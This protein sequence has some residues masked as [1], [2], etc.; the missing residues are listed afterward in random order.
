MR[1]SLLILAPLVL[2]ACGETAKLP[3]TAGQG[4]N[5]TLGEPVKTLL[6]TIKIAKPIGWAADATPVAAPGLAVA[7]FA[8]GL[9]HPRWLYRLP[10]GDVLVAETNGPPRP[11]DSSGVKGVVQKII[12]G[13]AGATVPSPNR[14]ILLRDANHDGVAETRTTFLTGLNSPFGMAMIGNDLYV[15]ETDKLTKFTY[16]P[17]ATTITTPGVKVADLPGGLRNHHWTKN[18][19]ASADGKT[20]YVSIGSNSNV[21]ENGLD[22]E[23]GRARIVTIDPASGA[24]K[25]FATGLRNPVG[26]AWE[27]VTGALWTSVN[28]RD[29]IGS[30]LVPDYMTS[31][32]A[33]AHYGWPWSWYGQHVDARVTPAN[34]A[35]VGAAIAPDYALGAHTASLGLTFAASNQTLGTGYAQGAFVGQH[36]SWN[37]SPPSGYKVVFVA[38]NGGK[39]TGL[40]RDVL[41]GFLNDKGQA[42]GRPVGVAFDTGGALLVADDVG[43]AVWRVSGVSGAVTAAR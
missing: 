36:G 38:F 4:G 23:I 35:M 18:V 42:H 22:A 5:P 33:G 8:R 10:N 39:P 31:V 2:V 1:A 37:R 43:N 25:A 26:M 24:T 15:A 11:E 41:T 6:P 7:A 27:P 19:V 29:E 3:V 34:P 32:K 14:I 16:T 20:L 40:P 12:M 21:A 9:D 28:E 30:D 13:T 17:G